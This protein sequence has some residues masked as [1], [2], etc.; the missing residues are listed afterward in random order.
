MLKDSD[1]IGIFYCFFSFGTIPIIKRFR[2][3]RNLLFIFF[4]SVVSFLLL[5]AD[6]RVNHTGVLSGK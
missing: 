6:T 3:L 1:Y 4:V 5:L 2:I